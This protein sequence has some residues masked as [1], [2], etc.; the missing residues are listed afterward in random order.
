MA[1]CPQDC[2]ARFLGLDQKDSQMG[3]WSPE[4][5]DWESP[6]GDNGEM[7]VPSPITQPLP[8][9]SLSLRGLAS[10]ERNGQLCLEASPCGQ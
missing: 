4:S 1:G 3:A 2:E 8:L 6:V 7:D 9:G 10:D 5:R